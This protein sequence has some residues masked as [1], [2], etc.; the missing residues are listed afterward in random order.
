M[1]DT[2]LQY[3]IDYSSLPVSDEDF[4]LIKEAFKS[5]KLR[6]RQYLLQEGDIC[7]YL[8]FICKGAL[9][10]YSVDDKGIE[11]IVRFGI[12]RWWVA[13]YESYTTNTPGR[14]NID[15]LEDA[16]LLQITY[17]H[18]NGLRTRVPAIDAML[19]KIDQRSYVTHQ[20]R[21]YASIS[22]TAEDRYMELMKT[23]PEFLQR[24]SQNMIASYLGISPET[25]SRIR[26]QM[27]LK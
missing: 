3:I 4:K 21:I 11:H 15:V 20:Q 6:K 2:L 9:R 5:K 25:L 13:D 12:E 27:T 10:Q 24:F 16:E 19:R 1:Y 17:E 26:K 7:K 23:Y 8:S 14:Y 22:L 18:L